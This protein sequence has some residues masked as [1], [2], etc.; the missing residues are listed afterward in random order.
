MYHYRECGLRNVWLANGY[1]KHETPYGEGVSIHDVEGL[2]RAI[3]RNLVRKPGKLTGTELRFL[4]QEMRLSQSKLAEM[5]GNEAQTIALWEKRGGQPKLADRF[6]RAIYRER[7]EGNAH[8]QEIIDRL[9]DADI[10]EGEGV[11]ITLEK[12]HHLDWRLAA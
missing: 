12:G 4:R 10:E 11:R 1:D 6:I 2:H 7:D 3:A 9:I 8:I 5:V